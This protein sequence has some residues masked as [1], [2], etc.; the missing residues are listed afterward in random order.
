MSPAA[1]S[2]DDLRRRLGA[3]RVVTDADVV[4][5][6]SADTALF[7][8]VGTALA[9]VRARSVDEVSAALSWAY[10]H[11]V[12]VVPQG[13]RTGLSG[14][15]N[16]VDGCL[17]LSVEKMDR[18]LKVDPVEQ[19]AVV[20]PGVLNVTL[21]RAAQE[22][23][24]TY[25]PDPSSWEIS[26]IGGNVATNAG[27]LCCVKYGVTRDF[28]RALQ[29][30]LADG[31]VIRTGRT[32]AKGVAG[33]DLTALLVG[34]EGTLGVI[35]EV[36]VALR[37]DPPPALTAAATFDDLR[38]AVQTVIDLMTSGVRPSL[39]ELM[40]GPTV[41]VV[42]RFRDLG[43]PTGTGAMLICSSDDPDRQAADL[44]AFAGFAR[45]HGGD[46]VVAE[47]PQEAELLIEA[48]RLVNPA[49]EPLGA[50]LVDDV[51]VPRG[52]L[53]ELIDGT[54]EIAARHDVM[55]TT[56]GHA[57]DGNM[58]PRVVFDDRDP[59]ETERAL[60]AFDAIMQLGIDLGG[61]ITGEHGVGRL[62]SRWLGHE[63]DA[64]AM[65][66]QRAIKQALDP[67][68]ILNPGTVLEA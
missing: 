38:A 21:T 28:V 66:V 24:L 62:K 2:L 40:D 4:A 17:L 32:T 60:A 61:T 25:P 35:T 20:E 36:T 22:H 58:H 29:V 7:A 50:S 26:T 46:V 19:L 53:V 37:P 54:L 34:S 14:G 13:A 55:V 5:A 65:A 15:A 63:L 42:S 11:R 1:D 49:H 3:E 51:C 30:V 57:G 43:L 52:R 31:T 10:E 12:P 16:A 41:E 23:G 18:V 48:R 27:G 33:Y 59:A 39:L 8:P 47:D 56:C 67:R 6:A 64:G 9:L 45:G 68:G 44:A